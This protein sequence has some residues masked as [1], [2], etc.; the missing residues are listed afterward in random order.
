M[1]RPLNAHFYYNGYLCFLDLMSDFYFPDIW[2]NPALHPHCRQLLQA[3]LNCFLKSAKANTLSLNLFCFSDL[4]CLKLRRVCTS[5]ISALWRSVSLSRLS[6]SVIATSQFSEIFDRM[7]TIRLVPVI[8]LLLSIT[9]LHT[10]SFGFSSS[11]A[12]P[13][14]CPDSSLMMPTCYWQIPS[15]G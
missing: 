1:T 3:P 7:W 12:L 11:L 2:G 5:S 14:N 6:K 10:Y 15:L 9:T 8:S 13:A 4:L